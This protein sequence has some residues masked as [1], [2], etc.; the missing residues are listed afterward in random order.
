MNVPTIITIINKK[1]REIGEALAK[2]QKKNLHLEARLTHDK[3][4]YERLLKEIEK[5]IKQLHQQL[6]KS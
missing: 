4:N 5:K 2:V 6:M 3:T 1:K